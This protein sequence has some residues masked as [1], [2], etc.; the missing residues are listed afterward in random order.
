MPVLPLSMYPAGWVSGASD[1]QGTHRGRAVPADI[2]VPALV[3]S[4][5]TEKAVPYTSMNPAR[6]IRGLMGVSR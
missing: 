4:T 2:P 3:W 5:L 1:R 6:T